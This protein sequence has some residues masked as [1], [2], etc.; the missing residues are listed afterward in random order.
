MGPEV[1]LKSVEFLGSLNLP[2][3]VFGSF[4]VLEFYAR[5]LGLENP[6]RP[7]DSPP[8]EPG[9]YLLESCSPFEFEPGR[10]GLGSGKAQVEFLE[11]AVEWAKAGFLRALVT[12][13]INKEAARLGGLNFPGHTEFF[14]HAFRVE[15]FAMMLANRR[16][17]VA[18]VT[19][20]VALADV[21]RL[22][23]K[24]A[25]LSK[26]LL[27][28]RYFPGKRIAVTGLNPHAGEGGLFGRE[29][30]EEIGPAVKEAVARGVKAFGPFPADTL[31]PKAAAGEFDVVLAM[32]HDQGLVPVKLLG[33]GQ[34]VNVTLG[35]PVVRTSVD[36][37]TAY[38]IVGKGVADPGSFRHAVELALELS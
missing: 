24:K 10:V 4:K 9:L 14:A 7:V 2:V 38:D 3:V 34:T 28:N 19:T 31:F 27:L 35:L 12:L 17:K 30:L 1:L 15:E 13:P 26:L 8:G 23:T 16:L 22:I 18:L 37:G 6:F 36:H 21:P 32:Y 20:H 29:E 11:R 5:L 25:V 33:F